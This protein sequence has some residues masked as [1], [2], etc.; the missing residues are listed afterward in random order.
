[1]HSL[2]A[3]QQF[4]ASVSLSPERLFH[5]SMK[6]RGEARSGG[7]CQRAFRPDRSTH[8]RREF[9]VWRAIS[10]VYAAAAGRRL[11]LPHVTI[12]VQ[13]GGRRVFDLSTKEL[14]RGKEDK[15][16]EK[17]SQENE[18]EVIFGFGD[19]APASCDVQIW[20][21]DPSSRLSIVRAFGSCIGAQVLAIRKDILHS[22][23][24][25]ARSLN[26]GDGLHK[27]ISARF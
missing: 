16:G 9:A 10:L 8:L 12:C 1:M 26:A 6:K 18:E 24:L 15:E 2:P 14:H 17:E 3:I 22:L 21:L 7:G 23:W 13:I 20:R 19:A 5:L 25:I 27:N 4:D 11:L